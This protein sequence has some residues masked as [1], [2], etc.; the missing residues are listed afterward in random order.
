MN[1]HEAETMLK[2][3][4]R[5]RRRLDN[6]TYLER[7]D[8]ETIAIRL[9]RTDVLSLM[10]DGHIV[11]RTGGWHTVTTRDRINRY[12]PK[13]WSVGSERGATILY[14]YGQQG[15]WTPVALV[16]NRV[17]ILPDGTAEGG[18]DYTAFKEEIRKADNERNR[19]RSR[20]R[21]WLRKAA[22]ILVDRSGCRAGQFRYQCATS[23]R[24]NRNLTTGPKECGC[25]V[26]HVTPW[27]KGLTV[28]SIMREENVTVRL[29]KM[30]IYGFERFLLDAKAEVIDREAGYELIGLRLGEPEP[31][32]IP[33]NL[34]RALKMTC[35]ST[36]AVYVNAVPPRTQR[37][38]EALDWVF[39][40]KG[41]LDHIGQ[42]A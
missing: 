7:R 26:Q 8:G 15:P 11:I 9:H 4:C 40:T 13:P 19:I 29:A 16:G 41:Y 24:W 34:V 2:G 36:G 14:T 21:Y 3:R 25:V 20:A 23:R 37:V 27:A 6:N 31:F 1:Y 17:D 28:E 32:T 22:G 18:N 30:K 39:N 38:R 35:P 33:H 42:A 10:A 5:E 12:L